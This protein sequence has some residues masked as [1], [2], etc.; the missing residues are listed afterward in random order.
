MTTAYTEEHGSPKENWSHDRGGSATRTLRC[1]WTDRW[2]LAGELINGAYPYIS[3]GAICVSVG[4][5]PADGKNLSDPNSPTVAIYSQAILSAVYEISNRSLTYIEEIEPTF[6]YATDD[7]KKFRWG[8]STGNVALPE[9]APGRLLI[10]AAYK[11]TKFNQSSIPAAAQTLMGKVN[12]SVVNPKMSIFS[13]WSF[14]AETLLLQPPQFNVR[15]SASGLT[16]TD[17]TYTGIWRP[18][19]DVSG[20]AKGWNWFW[21]TDEQCYQQLYLA[22]SGTSNTPY[23]PFKTGNFSDVL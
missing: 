1:A 9:E 14:A 13:G 16:T 7:Y 17:I 4:I 10:G 5:A 2:T 23:K 18:N 15:K 22:A 11:L 21:N 19:Y 3:N 20:N 8:S 12:S 6:E